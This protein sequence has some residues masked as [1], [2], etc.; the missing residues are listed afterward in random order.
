MT[1]GGDRTVQVP[2]HTVAENV[3]LDPQRTALI[4]VDMQNDFVRTDGKLPVAD[5]AAT[6]PVIRRLLDLA[7][8]TG[9]PVFYTQ[10]SHH[11]GDPEFEIWGEH[12]LVGTEGWK[13]VP[14]LEPEPRDQVVRKARYDGFHDTDLADRLEVEGVDTVVIC[15]TVANICVLHTAASA[16][17]RWYDVVL[18]LDATSAITPFDMESAIRQI[19]FLFRGTITRSDALVV[20]RSAR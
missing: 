7:H 20:G 10:D 1:E 13:I 8:E 12:C 14:E 15:G 18:P 16:A 4:V 19:A 6:V 5:A 17:I 3:E 2:E 9:I 11:A